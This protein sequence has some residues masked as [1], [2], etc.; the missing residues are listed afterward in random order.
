MDRM[1]KNPYRV[2]SKH[3]GKVLSFSN[4]VTKESI[5]LWWCSY[6]WDYCTWCRQSIPVVKKYNS[7][8]FCRNFY[9][10]LGRMI[11]KMESFKIKWCVIKNLNRTL[12]WKTDFFPFSVLSVDVLTSSNTSGLKIP[13]FDNIVPAPTFDDSTHVELPSSI[14]PSVAEYIQQ[15]MSPGSDKFYVSYMMFDTL[16]ALLPAVPSNLHSSVVWVSM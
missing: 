14:S 2:I 1:Q 16:G 13:K 8:Q 6:H 3:I 5:W 4:Q 11:W 15:V 7:E 12:T 10:A 9:L